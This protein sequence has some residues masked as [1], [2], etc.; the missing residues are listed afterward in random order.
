MYD[1]IMQVFNKSL[2]KANKLTKNHRNRNLL[3]SY[4]NLLVL[5]TQKDL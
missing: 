2:Q 3:K 1:L 4:H 5:Q